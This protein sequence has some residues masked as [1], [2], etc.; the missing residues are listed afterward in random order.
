[1]KASRV[2]IAI[3]LMTLITACESKVVYDKYND[4]P[5]AGWNKADLLNFNIPPVDTTGNYDIEGGLRING[6]FPFM[7]LTLIV[8]TTIVPRNI[9]QSDT[10][11]CQTIG[12]SGKPV[13][14]GVNFFQTRFPIKQ[15]QL[16]KGDSLH[17]TIRHDM[18]REDLPGILNV[19]ISLEHDN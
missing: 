4:T 9:T 10:I 5:V 6:A 14:Q 16:E 11:T 2:F 19:G 15:L 1:M 8:N 3:L 7:S 18:R 17:I 12:K 13:G